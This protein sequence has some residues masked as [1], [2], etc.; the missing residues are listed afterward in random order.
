MIA[1]V[2]TRRGCHRREFARRIAFA[3]A[4]IVCRMPEAKLPAR[5][6]E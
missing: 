6:V 1:D 5:A 4:W 2:V 3:V